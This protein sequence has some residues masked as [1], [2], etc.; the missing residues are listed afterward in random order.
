MMCI[1]T[2][3]LQVDTMSKPNVYREDGALETE[4]AALKSA[5]LKF[6]EIIN[7]GDSER[8]ITHQT[9][10]FTLIDMLG[11]TTRG[12][13]GW[14]DY[15]SS[16]PDY[17]IHVHTVL[18]G[19]S[20]VAIIGKTTGSHILPEIE[21][22]ETVLWTAEIRN[23]LVAEWR[24]YSDAEEI[25]KALLVTPQ[26]ADSRSGADV[27]LKF[28]DAINA[29]DSERLITHQTEDF[30]FIDMSGGTTRGRQGWEDYFSSY[31]DYTIHVHTVLL[32]GNGVAIIGKTTG[33]HV[34][35]EVEKIW[36]IL[37]TAEIR[38]NLVAEWRIYTDIEEAKKKVQEKQK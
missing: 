19:G 32:G 38:N 7:A 3:I 5:A 27:A 11:G 29:G 23:N 22:E 16:Y 37:W 4:V 35:P 10:D 25:E 18:T 15:F 26:A 31:P 21:E 14:E 8:L 36:N 33:S 24:I 6:V 34:L 28:V 1:D 20:S 17:T 9:E 13:Q 2:S 30:T 12:R